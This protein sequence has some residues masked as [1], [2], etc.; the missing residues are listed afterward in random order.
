MLSWYA[1]IFDSPYGNLDWKPL[2]P[3]T[4]VKVK[5]VRWAQLFLR[6]W[7]LLGAMGMLFCVICI[8]NT[9][10]TVGWIIRVAVSG[11]NYHAAI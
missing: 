9:E 5:W 8:R 1:D 2:S 11:L 10:S 6:T 4:K 7:T 3:R